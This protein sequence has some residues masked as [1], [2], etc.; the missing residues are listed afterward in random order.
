MR[1]YFEQ[2]GSVT[3]LKVGRSEKTGA[4]RGYAFVEFR[5]QEVAKTVAETMNNYLFF[6]K[7]LKCELVT[8]DKIRPSMFRN[9]INAKKPPLKKARSIAKREVN[10]ERDERQEQ[11]RRRK[12][13]QGLKKTAAKLKSLGVECS[14]DFPSI[15]K[16]IS[17]RKA[18]IKGTGGK[19]P[20]M[21]VDD[22]DLDITLKTPPN[23][24][25]IKSRNN[26]AATP[27]QGSAQ[28]S[29][30]STKKQM[31]KRKLAMKGEDGDG[32]ILTPQTNP[33]DKKNAV[34]LKK[35]KKIPNSKERRRS[36]PVKNIS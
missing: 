25:K 32:K 33:I 8:Q 14:V 36:E 3:N 9:K 19:T 5:Y 13:L 12:Q 28:I 31:K 11:K 34:S 7:L 23:V 24:R 15:E 21:A 35:S 26:S 22:S 10:K 17:E 20:T 2:F 30:L 6:D 27:R 29:E 18:R 1:K 16:E 4:S